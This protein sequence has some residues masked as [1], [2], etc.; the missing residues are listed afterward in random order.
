MI[1]LLVSQTIFIALSTKIKI[2]FLTK[3]QILNHFFIKPLQIWTF[4]NRYITFHVAW[5]AGITN[6]LKKKGNFCSKIGLDCW[7][8]DVAKYYPPSWVT[9]AVP[10]CRIT[11]SI[12]TLTDT[13][14][15]IAMGTRGAR[16]C[17]SV[18]NITIN[19]P[20][21]IFVFIWIFTVTG[22]FRQTTSNCNNIVIV[23]HKKT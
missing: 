6:S 1:N 7:Q 18:R 5:I 12:L 8:C 21:W 19:L 22:R 20:I 9:D 4:H 14:T 23:T 15:I 11:I 17:T 3:H 2:L 16:I 13:A 10:G